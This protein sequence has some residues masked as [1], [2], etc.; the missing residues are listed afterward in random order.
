[1]ADFYGYDHAIVINASVATVF[2]ASSALVASA[3]LEGCSR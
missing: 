1:M 3:S 2:D